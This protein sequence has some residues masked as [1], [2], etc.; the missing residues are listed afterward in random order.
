VRALCALRPAPFTLD[1]Q[2]A[3]VPRSRRRRRLERQRAPPCEA[4]ISEAW[5]VQRRPSPVH[6]PK[7][8]C[9][10]WER[11][12][13]ERKGRTPR[14]P[15][16]WGRACSA[17][18]L[19]PAFRPAVRVG[20]GSDRGRA[21]TIFASSPL[22]FPPP[23]RSRSPRRPHTGRPTCLLEPLAVAPSS[24]SPRP[25]ECSSTR[26][27]PRPALVVLLAAAPSTHT[28]STATGR[29]AIAPSPPCLHRRPRSTSRRPTSRSS[30]P[31]PTSRMP[32]ATRA[33]SS[34]VSTSS[35]CSTMHSG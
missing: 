16:W 7:R 13:E 23:L 30:A 1:G 3:A 21:A 25:P 8:G 28:S 24:P 4:R 26:P 6:A 9:E 18:V 33:A 29:C 2:A 27:S 10:P 32:R 34:G 12:R 19:S 15:V 20:E 5:I 35:S 14:A 17:P 31:A 11:E 22:P